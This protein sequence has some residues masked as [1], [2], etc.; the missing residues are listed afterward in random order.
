GFSWARMASLLLTGMSL[1]VTVSGGTGGGA[2]AGL[3]TLVVVAVDVG[4]IALLAT[5]G[6][7]AYFR[8]ARPG[9]S[10]RPA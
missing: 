10:P 4:I 9:R 2:V 3:L 8:R 7:R 6:G 1:I 5:R